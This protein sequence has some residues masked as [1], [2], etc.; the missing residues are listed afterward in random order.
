LLFELN[1]YEIAEKN[2]VNSYIN[3]IKRRLDLLKIKCEIV[4][5][6]EGLDEQDTPSISKISEMDGGD[7]S[8]MN[9]L[10]SSVDSS[11][12]TTDFKYKI[13]LFELLIYEDNLEKT[14]YFGI[15]QLNSWLFRRENEKIIVPSV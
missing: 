3:D 11:K 4:P 7:E 8:I 12:T 2:N 13:V 14:R 5:K 1:F 10:L 9:S 6:T 15:Q